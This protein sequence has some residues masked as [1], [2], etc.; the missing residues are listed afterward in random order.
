MTMFCRFV[1]LAVC[2]CWAA[3]E[4]LNY[5]P[6]VGVL[7]QRYYGP[8][9]KRNGP[10]TATYIA[11][12]YVKFLES[13]GARVVPV[14]VNKE[15]DYYV[16]L[17][18]SINGVLFPGGSASLAASGYS[19]A[20]KTLLNLAIAEHDNN[21]THFPVWGTCLGMEQLLYL[22]A[23]Q[24]VMK[25][26]SGKNLPASLSFTPD[27][28]RT[29]LFNHLPRALEWALK[30][31][32][33]T[34]NFHQWCITPQNFSRYGLD[35]FYEVLSTSR[36]RDSLEFISTIQAKRYPIYATQWHPEKAAFEWVD[37]PHYHYIPHTEAAVEAMQFVANFFVS[38]A[39]RN[40]HSF[41]SPGE[42]AKALIYN[43]NVTYM[44][45]TA[46][47]VQDYIFQL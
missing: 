46:S 43:Y 32:N 13:A 25:A 35:N 6:I 3:A 45:P 29:G 37:T 40:F 31:R 17:F 27:F 18:N 42:E 38:E 15:H 9:A 1:L 5:R 39:R 28:R 16:N 7:A 8:D 24:S 14:F 21:G 19:S 10:P 47:S 30:Q 41:S 11:A 26:C 20:A 4:K 34:Y 44:G 33:I 12:S 36:D 23:G 22:Q 2:Y